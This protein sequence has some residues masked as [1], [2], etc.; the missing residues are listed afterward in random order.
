MKSMFFFN[1]NPILLVLLGLFV[2]D[3][4]D[5]IWLI[6]VKF[7]N[8][9]KL[10]GFLIIS[11]GLGKCKIRNFQKIS[12][13]K[14]FFSGYNLIIL[15]VTFIT[16]I[17]IS[18]SK[19]T[20]SFTG[21]DFFRYVLFFPHTPLIHFFPL[22][23]FIKWDFLIIKLFWKLGIFFLYI[24][25]FILLISF[26]IL[27]TGFFDNGNL[28][29]SSR[30][31]AGESNDLRS[32][33][34]FL[35]IGTALL[36][37]RYSLIY[38][39]KPIQILLL[40]GFNLS[41]YFLNLA[42]GSRGAALMGLINLLVPFLGNLN[43]KRFFLLSFT[44]LFIVI[45]FLYFISDSV[46]LEYLNDRLFSDKRNLEFNESQR[47]YYTESLINDFNQ[48]PL[49]YFFGRG[50]FGTYKVGQIGEPRPD[51]EWGFWW[52][53]LKGGFLYLILYLFLNLSAFYF[54]YFKSRNTLCRVIGLNA[55]VRLISLVPFGIPTFSL[56]YTIS[57]L[58]LGL[59]F[60]P[61]VRSL[62]DGDLNRILKN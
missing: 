36:N 14:S 13:L 8:I 37:L 59:V 1:K 6:P 15:T 45:S 21:S 28:S 53:I 33:L 52:F 54:G 17:G 10:L 62:N 22:L 47:E 23:L 44:G 16:I 61:Q 57:I 38:F 11:I 27:Q 55:L 31:L 50:F 35:F 32:L 56:G 41:L 30:I 20:I 2:Y 25:L 46:Y 60:H 26:P 49:D 48:S 7:S 12:F 58:F 51:I 9:I 43:N 29:G 34:P 5:F 18:F 4:S 40:L 19:N 42:G 24:N 3:F 39:N